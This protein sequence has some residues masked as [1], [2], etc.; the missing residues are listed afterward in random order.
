MSINKNNTFITKK[1]DYVSIQRKCYSFIN[2]NG[3][4]IISPTLMYSVSKDVLNINLHF[5]TMLVIATF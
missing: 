3:Q 1:H 4:A 2:D 5:L